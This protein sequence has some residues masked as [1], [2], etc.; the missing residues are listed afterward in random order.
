MKY[1]N[2]EIKTKHMQARQRQ[3]DIPDRLIGLIRDYGRTSYNQGSW[4]TDISIEGLTNLRKDLPA[5]DCRSIEKLKRCYLIEA[6]AVEV[7]V[8][9]KK[10]GWGRRFRPGKAKHRQ[11]NMGA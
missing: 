8:A 7:T 1:K 4:V 2:C 3:R 11:Q 9:F 5:I 6:G 10:K